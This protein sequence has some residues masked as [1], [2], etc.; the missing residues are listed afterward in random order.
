MQLAISY[1]INF[2]DEWRYLTASSGNS[3]RS[4]RQLACEAMDTQIDGQEM[5]LGV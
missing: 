4:F 1:N 5:E 2:N 3:G